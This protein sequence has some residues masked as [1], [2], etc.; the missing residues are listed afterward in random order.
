MIRVWSHR[1]Q[2][3]HLG[4]FIAAYVLG[5]GFAQSLAIVPGTGISIWP[6]G[7]LFLATLVLASRHSWPWWILGGCLAELFGNF[8][9]FGSPLLVA[10][11]LYVANALEAVTGAWLINRY[12]GRPIRL[13]TLQETLAFVVLGAG[14]AP[15][16]G[17]T[18]GSATLVWFGIQSQSLT[19]AWPLWWIGDATG[20]LIV[21]PVV[22]VL[23]QNWRS[24]GHLSAARWIEAGVLGLIFLGVAALSLSGYLP[25]AYIIMPPLLWA[26]VRFEFKGAA[27]T[28]SLLALITAAFTIFGASQFIGDAE[29]QRQKQIML[30][31]FLGVSALSALIVAAISRQHQRALFTLSESERELSQLVNMV[32]SQ[33]WRLSPDGEPVFFNKRMVD[34]LG[35]EVADTD[36]PGMSRLQ[37]VVET[38]HPDDA[39]Q[40]KETLH[41]SLL[42]GE[43]FAMRYRLRRADGIYR[44]MSGRAEPMRDDSGRIVQWFGL[45]HDIEDQMRLYSD[46]EEREAKIRRLVDSDII[47]IVIWDLDGLLIDAN[48]AFLRMVQYEREDLQAGLR[49]FDMTPPEWQE[50]HA[51]YE[52][53]ELK[54]TGMMQ[55]REKEFFRKDGSRVP[56]LIGAA[57]FEGQSRQGVAYILDLTERKRAEAALRE[58]EQELSQLVN[59]VPIFIRRLTPEGEPIFF[60]KRFTDFIGMGLTEIGAPSTSRLS[61]TVDGFVHPDDSV[62]LLEAIRHSL[63]SDEPFS[64]KYRMRRVDGAY[65]WV[66]TR[67][68]PVRDAGGTIVQWYVVSID[69]DDEVRA[70]QAEEALRDTSIKLAKATQAA[71]LAELSASIAHEV[72]QPLAAIVANSHACQRWLSA[73]PSNVERA[74]ITVDRIIRDANSAADVVSRIRALFRQSVEP[75]DSAPLCGAIAEAHGLMAEEATRRR[76]QM[77]IDVEGNLPPV[78]FDR[79]QIQQVLINLIRNGFD[80]MDSTPDGRI[81]GMRLHRNGN[82]VQTEIS[83]F[84]MGIE[85]PDRIFEPFF[86]TKEQG[87]GMGLAICRSIVEGH[88]GRLWAEKNEPHGARFIFTLPVEVNAA[89]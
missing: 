78:A 28:L 80:A 66:D 31:L 3:S 74:K 51:R 53:E 27:I 16:V 30:H 17:A 86:T 82:S 68:E 73:D 87:M 5:C 39:S 84:G 75:R 43:S 36:R 62:G 42:T 72:N 64:M 60:N 7:G 45:C 88:G 13:E 20:I 81:L 8:F 19:T 33:V 69:V 77:K 46:I 71:S 2:F 48:D 9:W 58:R 10:V 49:W 1:P 79:V 44:W 57:C 6:P 40:F 12:C 37:A 32:P 65:R 61:P 22:L 50:V 25:F 24:K 29:T 89:K 18:V 85:F 54:R 4:I 55:A 11:L 63:A 41:H 70:Q 56:V 35:M 14:I 83:D 67:A 23:S 34:F 21:A 52:A 15:V 59:M 76:V 26:A 47:G 38:V